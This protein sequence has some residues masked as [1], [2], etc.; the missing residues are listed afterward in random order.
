[1]QTWKFDCH[2]SDRKFQKQK[3][4]TR[5]GKIAKLSNT[6]LKGIKK[7][8]I[9]TYLHDIVQKEDS[10][11]VVGVSLSKSAIKTRF[12]KSRYRGFTIRCKPFISLKN[13]KA[14]L[15]FARAH[16]MEQL[17]IDETKI[18]LYQ[19]DGKRKVWKNL[20]TALDP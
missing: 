13:R 10:L 20:G 19:N 16:Y 17:W 3:H 5:T 12:H 2:S 15:E 18:N 6:I 8:D 1:M 7:I 9:Y 11:G 14:R 4:I